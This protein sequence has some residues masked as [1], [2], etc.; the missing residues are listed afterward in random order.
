MRIIY[1]DKEANAGLS[2][3]DQFWAYNGFDTLITME[4]VEKLQHKEGEA[5][6]A[7]RM[8][9]AMQ[10]PAMVMMR[11]GVRI[12][13]ARRE[14]VLTSFE[15]L[16]DRYEHLF[17]TIAKAGFGLPLPPPPRQ[18][19]RSTKSLQHIFY[20]LLQLPVV[21]KY[22]KDTK[23]ETPSVDRPALEKLLENPIA[24]PLA[25]IIL[26]LRDI[27][28]KVQVLA[29]R[30]DGGRLLCSYNVAG[31]MTGR[32]SSSKNAFG[33]GL[34]LQ[35]V[36]DELRRICIADPGKK[37]ACLDLKQAESIAVAH[38]ALPWGDNYLRA[39]TSGDI[40]TYVAKLVWAGLPWSDCANRKEEK[41]LAEQKVYRDF[42]YRDL[43]KRGGHASNYGA[44]PG[45][46][47]KHLKIPLQ[48]AE[49][50]QQS[51]FSAFPEIKQWH[52]Q[53]KMQLAAHRGMVTPLG[54]R[55]HFPG[56]PWDSE[57][58]KSA[59]AYDP[60][61]HIGDVLNIGL[62]KVWRKYDKCWDDANPLELLL[63]VHDCIVFQYDPKDEEWLIPAVAAELVVPVEING[64]MCSI[65]SDAKVGWNW[66]RFDEREN[67]SGLAD[68]KGRD[69]R[70]P[71]AEQSV[72]DRRFY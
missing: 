12:D 60:Q 28:K 9:R 44:V 24:K 8:G 30:D 34:N 54:R 25:E 20:D 11:R 66:G 51:Y 57:T 48:L 5:S 16:R 68:Y 65:E 72:L 10:G 69:G 32:W 41:A 26:A 6:F 70:K 31:T 19:H 38:F 71:P 56:R 13:P 15:R 46:I 49:A 14:A 50:F 45:T 23:Q 21:Y 67:P 17:N 58:I 43:A 39:V 59:I 7:Y 47:A 2:G 18:L 36:T 27:D 4:I 55:C 52:N 53:V 3:Q 35:N 40:H 63:Q 29:A 64:R 22:N 42:S 61:S 37:L 1:S 62:Y 33:F